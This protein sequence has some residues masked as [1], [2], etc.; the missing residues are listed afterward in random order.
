MSWR[1][2]KVYNW[3][4]DTL[5]RKNQKHHPPEKRGVCKGLE[6]TDPCWL[7]IARKCTIFIFEA[8][9]NLFAFFDFELFGLEFT[10]VF[11][12]GDQHRFIGQIV[13]QAAFV[14]AAALFEVFVGGFADVGEGGF[15]VCLM[16]LI[17]NIN[18]LFCLR[19]RRIIS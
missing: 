10:A 2:G 4:F 8:L 17:L 3:L 18:S 6:T 15:H 1:T 19:R 12:V 16:V 11:D 9:E 13:L 14:N 5:L 7:Q